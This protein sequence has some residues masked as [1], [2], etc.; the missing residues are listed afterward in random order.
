M[1]SLFS[2]YKCAACRCRSNPTFHCSNA[3]PTSFAVLADQAGGSTRSQRRA[4]LSSWLSATAP[5]AFTASPVSARARP[6]R[7]CT[8]TREHAHA[9]ARWRHK[10]H[11]RTSRA[12]IHAH[13]TREPMAENTAMIRSC[14][15]RSGSAPCLHQSLGS[16]KR[17]ATLGSGGRCALSHTAMVLCVTRA[18]HCG[19]YLS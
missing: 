15:R 19:A 9:R 18:A 6:A 8:H 2:H 3:V 16:K 13:V 14:K 5:A 12:H 17:Q 7:K 1:C 11:A 10:E 4:S